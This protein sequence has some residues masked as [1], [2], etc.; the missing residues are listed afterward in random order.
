MWLDLNFKI[1]T[2]HQIVKHFDIRPSIIILLKFNCF[3]CLYTGHIIKQSDIQFL[4]LAF[5]TIY[6]IFDHNVYNDIYLFHI[7]DHEVLY[8]NNILKHFRI[9]A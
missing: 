1:V 3:K 4:Q 6:I 9:A 8:I 7:T 2:R 5:C